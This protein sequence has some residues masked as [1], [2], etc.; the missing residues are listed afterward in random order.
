MKTLKPVFFVR[1]LEPFCCP[2]CRGEKATVI[3]SRNRK[4][5]ETSEGNPQTKTIRIRRLKCE[6]CSRIHHELPGS[7]IPYKRHAVKSVEAVLEGNISLVIV[8]NSTIRR[9]VSWFDGLTCHLL[10]VLNTMTKDNT[11]EK[12]PFPGTRLQRL[13]QYVGET[14][15][16]L[17]RVVHQAVKQNLWVQTRSAFSAG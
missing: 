4:I 7:V 3:G 15:G 10:G 17:S 6:S 1:S 13:R 12:T 11:V 8:E 9:W 14:T 2:C 16:W 5:I